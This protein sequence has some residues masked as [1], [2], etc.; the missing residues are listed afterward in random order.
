[1]AGD[2]EVCKGA[3]RDAGHR[4]RH[5]HRHRLALRRSDGEEGRVGQQA[6]D[7]DL[8]RDWRWRFGKEADAQHIERR[9][10]ASDGIPAE[11]QRWRR[12]G[13]NKSAKRK[14]AELDCSNRHMESRSS[15]QPV[16]SDA[17]ETP[18]ARK[19]R[20]C[21]GLFRQEVRCQLSEILRRQVCR[22]RQSLAPFILQ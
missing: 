20:L 2:A 16:W 11:K 17:G 21:V 12:D 14:D 8:R 1:M 15:I 13:Y 22:R 19:R 18:L 5:D 10:A 9:P 6:G 7:R 4:H 3:R